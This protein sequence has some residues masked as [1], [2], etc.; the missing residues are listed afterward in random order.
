MKNFILSWASVTM[1]LF[2]IITL[3]AQTTWTVDNTPNSGAQFTD[4]QSAINAA[5]NGD[6]IYV[7]QSSITYSGFTIDKELTIIGRGHSN[8]PN[9]ITFLNGDTIKLDIGS[10]GSTIKG[11]EVLRIELVSNIQP[12]SIDDITISQCKGIVSC[13]N[14]NPNN[15]FNNWVIEGNYLTEIRFGLRSFNTLIRNNFINLFGSNLNLSNP[16]S[17]IFT[18]NVIRLGFG[19][20]TLVSTGGST[21]PINIINCII[22]IPGS[23][24]S[25]S[26]NFQLNNCLLYD[27]GSFPTTPVTINS[28][29]TI[30][31]SSGII[32][33]QDPLFTL[34][35]STGV[36][37]PDLSVQSGSPAIGAGLSGENIGYQAN[38]V[39]KRFGN[40]KGYP[41]VR[42]SNYTGST[43]QNG[44]VTFDIEARSH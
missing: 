17:T 18:N 38:Y 2:N 30:Q 5:S 32:T 8:T 26:A 12:G 36:V 4:V 31:N 24:L 41:E 16:S 1:L 20:G 14:N 34:P 6:T 19:G 10:T 28:S 35:A 7:Q 43:F 21:Q 9:Y 25:I 33:G 39:F 13:A 37:V 11:F 40:P 29:A 3:Q 22:E 23:T 15:N 44:T 27:Y 42:I